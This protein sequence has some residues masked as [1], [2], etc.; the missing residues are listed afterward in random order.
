MREKIQKIGTKMT[1]IEKAIDGLGYQGENI[2]VFICG[3]SYLLKWIDNKY[4]VV[5]GNR[6]Q[7]G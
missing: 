7:R 4:I 5:K 3:V 1:L 2:T 6:F